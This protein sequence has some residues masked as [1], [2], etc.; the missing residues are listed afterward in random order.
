MKNLGKIAIYSLIAISL[1]SLNSTLFAAKL[2]KDFGSENKVLKPQ[3][4]FTGQL[5]FEGKKIGFL[6][7][8]QRNAHLF[9]PETPK[10]ISLKGDY[11]ITAAR[12]GSKPT[13]TANIN[14][15]LKAV[16]WKKTSRGGY[17][18]VDTLGTSHAYSKILTLDVPAYV[19]AKV[20][21]FSNWL[22]KAT[23]GKLRLRNK[24]EDDMGLNLENMLSLSMSATPFLVGTSYQFGK[25]LI[26]SYK[27]PKSWPIHGVS[28]F[29]LHPLQNGSFLFVQNRGSLSV[30]VQHYKIDPLSNKLKLL[31]GKVIN[32]GKF[33][34]VPASVSLSSGSTYVFERVGTKQEKAMQAHRVLTTES[35]LTYENAGKFE[36]F[37]GIKSLKPLSKNSFAVTYVS[38]NRFDVYREV[39]GSSRL[40]KFTG[41]FKPES[42]IQILDN[43]A[44]TPINRMGDYANTSNANTKAIFLDLPTSNPNTVYALRNGAIHRFQLESGE[45][46]LVDVVSLLEAFT[47]GKYN[48]GVLKSFKKAL[49][50]NRNIKLSIEGNSGVITVRSKETDTRFSIRVSEL[51]NSRETQLGFIIGPDWI[52]N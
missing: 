37:S 35:G 48:L 25:E 18:I 40:E 16:V 22:S 1:S 27:S 42:A 20:K 17:E 12:D 15:L 44:V 4:H 41:D 6:P 52:R 7:V 28:G 29:N 46:R 30:L 24:N 14:G 8:N 9:T 49:A 10:A 11:I 5:Y 31:S 45:A 50:D 38:G 3:K 23:D 32:T 34:Y 51:F 39:K 2:C 36:S 13:E 33:N 21:E 19:G 43:K 26:N 47:K